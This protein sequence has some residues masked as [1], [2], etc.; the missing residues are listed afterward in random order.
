LIIFGIVSFV[1]DTV[2]P[3]TI[4]FGFG[5]VLLVSLSVLSTMTPQKNGL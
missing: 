2:R 5:V 3:S 1:G 4:F